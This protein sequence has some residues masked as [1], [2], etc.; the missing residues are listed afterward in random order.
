[1]TKIPK[2]I[3]HNGY[4]MATTDRE[5]FKYLIRIN[6]VPLLDITTLESILDQ[7]IDDPEVEVSE[8]KLL[9]TAAQ[10]KGWP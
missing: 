10:L 4:F 6:K 9:I 3:H 2:T 7:A 8:F 5:V 1:M